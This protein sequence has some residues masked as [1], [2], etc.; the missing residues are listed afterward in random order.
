MRWRKIS[1]ENKFFKIQNFEKFFPSKLEYVTR[2][3]KCNN[4]RTTLADV[5]CA[6]KVRRREALRRLPQV[7]NI[8]AQSSKV[9]NYE[10]N[11]HTN[12]S[13]KCCWNTLL[14]NYVDTNRDHTYY[15]TAFLI[16]NGHY[17]ESKFGMSERGYNLYQK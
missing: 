2:C 12:T 3:C 15:T 14:R 1:V 5:Q 9:K 11:S 4:A 7:Q 6:T 10:L 17:Y 16:I 8:R 13:N